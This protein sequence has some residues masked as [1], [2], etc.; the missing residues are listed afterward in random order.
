VV[1]SAYHRAVNRG[2]TGA[3]GRFS[4]T[5]NRQRKMIVMVVQRGAGYQQ[6]WKNDQCPAVVV[7]TL[8]TRIELEDAST[9][10]CE[11]CDFAS[12]TKRMR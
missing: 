10:M 1:V 12:N 6:L 4:P 2:V 11:K 5:R 9:L 3:V 8:I 7:N